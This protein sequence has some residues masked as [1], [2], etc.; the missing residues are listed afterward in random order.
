MGL[1]RRD[2]PVLL[3][4]LAIFLVGSGV[5]ARSAVAAPVGA[6]AR[7]ACEAALAVEA[8]GPGG[9]ASREPC[10]S[11]FIVD[12]APQDMR[13]EVAS[14]MSPRAHPSLDDLVVGSLIADAAV[15]K[16]P[17]EPWGYLARCDIARRLGSA[18]VLET[19]LSDLRRVAPAHAATKQALIYAAERAPLAAWILRAVLALGLLGTLAHAL[20]RRRRATR[21]LPAPLTAASLV[22]LVALSALSALAARPARAEPT[23]G[24]DQLSDF[25][26]DDADPEA[27]VPG[28]EMQNRKPLEFGYYLQD[29]AAKAESAAKRGDPAG[30]ARYY[31][32]LSKAAPTASFGPRKLCQVLET[33]GDLPGA[34]VACRTTLTREGSTA[35]DYLH[36]VRVVLATPGTPSSGERAELDAVITHLLNEAKLGAVPFVLRCEV[37]LRFSDTP[38]LAACTDILGKIAPNDPKTVSFQWALALRQH[39]RS[40]ARKLVDRARGVGVSKDGVAKMEEATRQ[41]GRSRLERLGLAAFGAA[42]AAALL[43]LGFRHLA[44]RRRLAV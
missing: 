6:S 38:A 40:A 4:R 1:T 8:S 19:C 31:K 39:D 25:K 2:A 34:V 18:D 35:G 26:I 33:A 10:H 15:R 23:P 5:L 11:A 13:N 17:S 22:G 42:V 9:P 36:F 20:L 44:Q 28:V 14:L 12:G 7:S 27:S 37:A 32:A 16:A 30:E 43:A 29:L 3:A 21:R 41:M 24:K